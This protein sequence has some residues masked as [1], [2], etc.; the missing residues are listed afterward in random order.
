MHCCIRIGT[1]YFA[2]AI[3]NDDT[4]NNKPKYSVTFKQRKKELYPEQISA[5]VL[6][7]LK[8]AAECYLGQVVKNAVITVPAYFNETQRE[9]TK[10]AAAIAGLN[11]VKVINEPAA[12]ALAFGYQST[13]ARN[14]LIYD[15]GKS[16]EFNF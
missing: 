5:M 9:S 16:Y 11:T 10:V 2:F 12:A 4:I 13:Q 8:K 6:T 7:E 1:E 3:I 15:L 14:V